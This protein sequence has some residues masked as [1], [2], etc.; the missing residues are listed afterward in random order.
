MTGLFGLGK[1]GHGC[2]PSGAHAA[3][4]GVTVPYYAECLTP[5]VGLTAEPVAVEFALYPLAVVLY[6]GSA[7]DR[8]KKRDGI[9]KKCIRELTLQ[10]A[11][12][13]ESE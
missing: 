6:E 3:Y 13:Y 1:M 7:Y 11:A 8:L 2:K 4:S 5:G 10:V 12:G 9:V